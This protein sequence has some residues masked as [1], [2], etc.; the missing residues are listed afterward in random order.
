MSQKSYQEKASLYLIP[1]PIGNMEDMTYRAI[2]T[3]EMVDFV[4]CEDTR[5]TGQL[6][7][8]YQIQ[9]RLIRSDEKVE[10]NLIPLVITSLREGKNVGLVTDRGTPIISDPGYRIASQVIKEGLS[11]ISLPGATAFVPAL[12]SSGLPPSPFLFYGFLQSKQS[13]R[14]EELKKLSLFP[15]TLIFYEAPHRISETLEDLKLVFGNRLISLHREISKLYEEIYRGTIEDVQKES[16]NAKGEMVIVV[17]GNEEKVDYS[18]LSIK[19][20]V[21]LYVSDGMS[22]MEAMKLVAK[23]RHMAKSMI[24][25]EYHRKEEER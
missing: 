18:S 12:T 5:V 15:Y 25:Q 16:V 7:H 23:E 21:L 4:L 10:E 22:E 20:H 14:R 8:Y 2:K 19:E 9:K 24:Y 3:L 6:L 11:V 1:T 17:S 13:K